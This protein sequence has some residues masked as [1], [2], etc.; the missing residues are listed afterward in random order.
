[1]GFS[2]LPVPSG[3][4][5]AT[6]VSYIMPSNYAHRIYGDAVYSALSPSLMQRIEPY[7]PL[8]RLGLHGSDLLFYYQPFRKTP[9]GRMGSGLH[10]FSG[11]AVI[12]CLLEAVD[13]LPEEQQDAGMAYVLG[14]VCHYLLDSACRPYVDR[15][16]AA[17][18]ANHLAIEGE[19][20]LW[21][22]VEEGGTPFTTDPVSHLT[23][24]L[25]ED[26]EILAA[27]YAR[28]SRLSYPDAPLKE[29]PEHIVSAHKWMVIVNH[30]FSSPR[31]W[32]RAVAVVGLMLSGTYEKRK[33]V[34]YHKSPDPAFEGCSRQLYALLMDA[35]TEAPAVLEAVTRRDLSHRFD[36]DFGGMIPK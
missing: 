35:A 12:G 7:M 16:E 4:S 28:L 5:H 13:D 26:F 27:L 24:L 34:L 14:F 20:D 36:A 31:L 6:E 2:G 1:M 11:R 18:K 19:F 30:F 29:R 33:G 9:L 23:G 22:I 25:P 15:L 17:G 3:V 21:L 10:H 8:F 32:R